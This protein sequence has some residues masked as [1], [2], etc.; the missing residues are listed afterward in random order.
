M[1]GSADGEV[2]GHAG[3]LGIALKNLIRN[4]LR[5]APR[6]TEVEIEVTR[7]PLAI[8]V[9]DRGPGVPDELK[10]RLFERFTRGKAAIS[11]DGSGIGLAIVESVARAHGAQA[12]IAARPGGGSIFSLVWPD[13]PS[14]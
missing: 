7:D 6:G 11:G 14:S 3:M 13:G 4:A 5:H 2:S 9:L 12:Q 8:R 10:P 1:N